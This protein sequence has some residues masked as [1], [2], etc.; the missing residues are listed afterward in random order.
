[1]LWACR[2]PRWISRG[3]VARDRRRTGLQRVSNPAT[4]AADQL[5]R[6][7]AEW[8]R[9]GSRWCGRNGS[10]SAKARENRFL[11]RQGDGR[12]TGSQ[13]DAGVRRHPGCLRT[14][15]R[16]PAG[17]MVPRRAHLRHLR[18]HWRN[19]TSDH[20]AGFARIHAQRAKLGTLVV[21]NEVVAMSGHATASRVF[22][23]SQ[24]FITMTFTVIPRLAATIL[25]LRDRDEEMEVWRK[26]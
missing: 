8:R 10:N 14:F 1:M 6:L 7:E 16:S 25:F 17:K 19:P 18:G 15:G 24:E 20:R 26:R 12:A 21:A 4:A 9:P 2:V 13:G 5:L 11:G 3:K 23:S 22:S